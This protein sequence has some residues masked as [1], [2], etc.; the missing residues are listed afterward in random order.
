MNRLSVAMIVRDEAA[1]LGGC[2]ESLAPLGAQV[3]VV[4][5]GST[6]ETIGI[7]RAH[8]AEVYSFPW[9]NDFSAARNVSI[10]HCTAPWILVMDA[11]ER[12]AFND[13][14]TLRAQIAGE[15]NCGYRMV[16]RNYTDQRHLTEFHPCPP[17]DLL[18]RSY[19]GWFPS[20]K[21]RLFPNL[22]QVR[23]AGA[24]HELVNPAL[25]ALGLPIHDSPVPVHHY[26]LDKPADRIDH[27]REFYAA[28]GEE[29]AAR[30]PDNA[31]AWE[32]LAEQYIELGRIGDAAR[33]Y[34]HAVT[35]APGEA[36][37][38]SGLGA[39]LAL[40]GQD[41]PA[42]AALDLALRLDPTHLQ[43]LRNRAILHLRADQSAAA[44][45]LLQ[46][47]LALR[48]TDAELHRVLAITLDHLGRTNEAHTHA[49]QAATLDPANEEAVALEQELAA[50]L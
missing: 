26:P 46:Q 15:P 33:A 27:K 12:L 4:D 19:P 42:A 5:T 10:D 39:V 37:M 23:F 35:A 25:E 3:V 34:R 7:A 30:E 18:A 43:A 13:L 38:L 11:D 9:C 31:K 44:E 16:T 20:S 8:G 14:E 41:A 40:A 24:V 21:V 6:D 2:L 22:P 36:R 28:L 29:K 1:Q 48:P 32:E 49:Q 50:R 47:A 45:P 17:G